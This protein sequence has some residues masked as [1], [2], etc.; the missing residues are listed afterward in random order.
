MNKPAA[1]IFDMDGTIV[2]N[3]PVHNQVWAWILTQL[4][5]AMP[6]Q[7][8]H[9]LTTGKRNVEIIRWL[10]GDQATPERVQ[11][12]SHEK[13]TRYQK[14]YQGKITPMPGLLAFF[15][16]ATQQ[17]IPLALATSADPTNMQFVVDGLGVRDYFSAILT[18]ADVR[19]GKPDPEIFLAAAERMGV[20]PDS[21]IVF[22]DALL[23]LEA[24]HRAGMKSV[25]VC[26]TLDPD[27]ARHLPG[28]IKTIRTFEN[29]DPAS[30]CPNGQPAPGA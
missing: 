11:A 3:M 26:T 28:V 19:Q 23:G 4:G 20:S 25:A 8:F 24:A 15:E 7:E 6:I 22:E 13:E 1:F 17:S 21:C 27:S 16:A 14:L 10:L 2:D 18:A 12:L 5:N 30:C 29:L 9:H